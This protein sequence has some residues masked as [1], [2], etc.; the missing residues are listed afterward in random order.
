MGGDSLISKWRHSNSYNCDPHVFGRNPLQVPQ[1]GQGE[2]PRRTRRPDRAGLTAAAQQPGGRRSTVSSAFIGTAIGRAPPSRGPT[3]PSDAPAGP[4]DPPP[5]IEAKQLAPEIRGE[6]TTLDKSPQ[7]SSP[8][9]WWPPANC[10]TRI[11]RPHWRMP[12]RP[13]HARAGSPPYAK[14]SASPP[15]TAVTGRR[16]SPNCARPAGWAASRRCWR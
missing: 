16:P 5:D 13:A 9:T 8:A 2:K 3:A 7:T 15:I 4:P 10:S 1:E 11:P 12:A 6:L 14:P